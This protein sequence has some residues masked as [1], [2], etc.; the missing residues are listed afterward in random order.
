MTAAVVE[1]LILRAIM[2]V[3]DD[4]VND[5]AERNNTATTN[6]Q[7]CSICHGWAGVPFGDCWFCGQAPS[8]HHGRC[9]PDRPQSGTWFELTDHQLHHV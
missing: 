4:A 9:C 1:L 7:R 5:G 2:H 3:H 8:W 6:E